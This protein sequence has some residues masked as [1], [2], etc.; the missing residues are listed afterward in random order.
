MEIYLI[1]HTTPEVEKGICYGQSDLDLVENHLEEFKNIALKI[2]KKTDFIVY[3]SPLKRC[4][5]LAKTFNEL[6]VFDDRLKELHFGDWELKPWNDISEKE[7]N[8][9]MKD[10]VNTAVPNG[11][12]YTQL[13]SRVH[14]FFET[15]RASK[16]KKDLIIVSHAGPIRAFLAQMLDIPLKDSFKIKI[17]YGDVFHLN[18]NNETFKLITEID[19]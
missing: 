10:F 13:A 8:P 5:L 14:I 9:W 3:S 15:I 16:E 18:L 12:S 7:L 2:P 1:R 17:N 11:E 19:L 6:V 4:A